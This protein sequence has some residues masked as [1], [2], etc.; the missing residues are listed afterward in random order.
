MRKGLTTLMT[1]AFALVCSQALA[2]AP[3]IGQI[4]SPIVGNKSGGTQAQAYT[5]PDAFD[6]H[7]LAT[8]DNTASDQL[9]WSYEI[10]GTPKFGINGDAPI[11]SVSENV[12]LPPAAK[13][14]NVTWNGIGNADA[15]NDPGYNAS[16]TPP[17][18]ANTVTIRNIQLYPYGGSPS[19]DQSAAA[20]SWANNMQPVTFW[21]SDG[22]LA[23]SSSVMFYTD[24]TYTAG[25]ASGWNRL[26]NVSPWTLRK[27]DQ[28]ANTS[29]WREYD[30]FTGPDNHTTSNT[31]TDGRGL[32]LTVTQTGQNWG[33]MATPIGFVTLTDNQVYRIRLKMNCTQLTSGKTPFWDF[34]LENWDGDGAH[35]QNFYGVDNYFIDN[36]GGAN[37]VINKASGTEVTMLWAP[38]AF[39][40]NQ[41]RNTT[42]GIFA[43]NPAP[44]YDYSL[45][46]DAA[47]RFRVL[48]LDIRSDLQN[49]QK[50]GSICMQNVIVETCPISRRVYESTGT[51]TPP[52]NNANLYGV[53]TGI[54]SL[55]R[56]HN[57]PNDS[58]P[59]NL[60]T[61]ALLGSTM[62]FSGGILSM[63]PSAAGSSAEI[64]QVTP[65]TNV[66]YVIG[67]WPTIADDWPIP[68]ESDKIY[69][70]KVDLS[71][72]STT[73]E[74]HPWD[75]L[76]MNM[77]SPT[78]ELIEESY[79]TANKG[80]ATP[81]YNGGSPQPYYLYF[82]SG[83]ET[84]ATTAAY[85]FLRW[86]IR[87][88]N[89]TNANWPN[90]SNTTNTG[91]VRIHKIVVNKV[92]FE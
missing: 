78:N 63:T 43:A 47:L 11:N 35:G 10:I 53:G 72:P 91:T 90:P 14:I 23:T 68:W 89:T 57:N 46:K 85:H 28:L 83:K 81:K 69:E 59:G 66:D 54:V 20:Q 8:D 2:M 38:A 49:N 84:K 31:W 36:E 6:L 4:P 44:G 29:N 52:A 92:R 7:T 58:V 33:S 13:Q 80:L 75:V 22:S 65:A 17:N 41:W 45:V 30:P 16:S 79:I 76:W 73:M 56:V 5:Y 86:R 37:A 51:S 55:K 39:Q 74:A 50:F 9:K 15:G 71:A 62:S 34:I 3:V 60:Y 1:V 77:E 88:G 64:V 21:C 25:A 40:T 70:L 18:L 27:Q 87:F 12:V 32:C 19:T 48:D 26:S 67:N 61:E 42:N 82:Y 24:N